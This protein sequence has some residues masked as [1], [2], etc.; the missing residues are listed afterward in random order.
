M[1]NGLN[2]NVRS[3]LSGEAL[4]N[5]LGVCVDAEVLYC[6]GITCE[7]CESASLDT[8]GILQRRERRASEGLHI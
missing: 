4:E 6:R 1:R 5:D 8:G 2:C 3:L 7:A